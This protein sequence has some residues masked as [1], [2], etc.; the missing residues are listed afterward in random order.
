MYIKFK[1]NLR[2]PL[3]IMLFIVFIGQAIVYAQNKTILQLADEYS[4]A[5]KKYQQQK[6]QASVESVLHKG[7]AVNNKIEVILWLKKLRSFNRYYMYF[8]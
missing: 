5:L 6:S 7:K 2:N 3:K 1:M 8:T 4:I